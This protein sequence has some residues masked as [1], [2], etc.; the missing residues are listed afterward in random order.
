VDPLDYVFSLEKLGIKFGLHN[1]G[2][3]CEALGHPERA[4]RSVIVAGT[5]GKGSVTAMVETALRAAGLATARYTSPHLIRLEERFVINSRPVDP[6]HLRE[7][8]ALMPSIVARLRER[9]ELHAEPTFFEVTTAIGFELFRRAAVD[10]AVLEVGMGGRFDATSIAP[11]CAAAITSIDF[12]HERYLGNTLGQIAFE[13]AGVIKRGMPVVV[14]ESKEEPLS[15]IAEACAERDARLVRA[16]DGV[17]ID[18]RLIDGRTELRL[19]TPRR[20]YPP[21]RLALRGRHQVINAV[22][23]VRLLEEL[24]RLGQPVSER[25]IAAGLT[26]VSW[27]GRLDLMTTPRGPVLFD[28]AHNPAGATVLAAYLEEVYPAGVPMVFGAMADKDAASMLRILLPRVT[29]LVVTRPRTPRARAAQEIAEVARQVGNV[30]VEV[31][32]PAIEALTRAHEFGSPVLVAG[33]IFLI[34]DLMADLGAS[35]RPQP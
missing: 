32:E 25:A 29:R 3:L 30:A 22:V 12:D 5:N 34:G 16:A 13:K 1:I 15:V 24:E 17:S 10:V 14:G 9:D 21:L 7:V 8:A 19:A 26:E 23:A 18:T 4:Y 33:S 2:V 28:G 31:V 27:R 6:G 35:A 20:R 11:A